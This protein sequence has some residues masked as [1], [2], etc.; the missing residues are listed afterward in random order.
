MI[1]LI[2]LLIYLAGAAATTVF[3]ARETVAR[4]ATV[5]SAL[6]TTPAETGLFA[7]AIGVFWPIYWPIEFFIIAARA[8]GKWAERA[9]Q[10]DVIIEEEE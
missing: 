10:Q 1:T 5:V 2:A 3:V 9:Q 4:N 6:H 8:I 7:L